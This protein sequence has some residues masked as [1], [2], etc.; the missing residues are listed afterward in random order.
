M[1][2]LILWGAR[3]VE[4]RE[5]ERKGERGATE[6]GGRERERERKVE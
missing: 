4:R 5:I 3:R 2:I 6:D 1:L